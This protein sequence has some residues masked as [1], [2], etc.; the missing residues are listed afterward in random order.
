MR[1]SFKI[2]FSTFLIVLLSLSIG[3]TI[4]IIT[5]FH[6]AL[7]NEIRSAKEENH[8]TAIIMATSLSPYMYNY[9]SDFTAVI[10]GVVKNI[11]ANIYKS[12]KLLRVYDNETTL[13]YENI[14]K[15]GL[16]GYNKSK[17]IDYELGNKTAYM[18]IKEDEKYYIENVST[19]AMGDGKVYIETFSDIT[20]VLNF[21]EVQVDIFLKVFV[22]MG[23]ISGILNYIVTVWLTKPISQLSTATRSLSNGN[24]SMRVEI[25]TKDEVGELAKDFNMMA[26]SMEKTIGE[27]KE[28]AR[29][30]EEFVSNFAHELKTPLTAVIGYADMLRSRKMS[31][32]A[33]FLAANYIFTEGERLES[34]SLKMLELLVER[35]YTPEFKQINIKELI[36]ETLSLMKPAL[37]K[38]SIKLEE[39]IEDWNLYVDKDLMK[40]V[41]INLID[42]AQKAIEDIGVI[43]VIGRKEEKE[44]CIY[45]KD[46]GRGIPEKD[47]GKI[48]EAFYMVDKSRSRREG[49]AGLGLN[50]CMQII[51]IHKAKLKFESEIGK[52]TTVKII[53]REGIL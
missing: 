21:I 2:F 23:L 30:Q 51:K 38:K 25:K 7:R 10:E 24:L 8:M 9:S 45:I 13:V 17:L 46:N 50:I 33:T 48:T 26:D 44:Y 12:E 28:Y 6:I 37:I 53:M 52:G 18:I 34:L 3:G 11:E 40:T 49:G 32:E 1:F 35:N 19:I 31:E 41:I 27:L 43:K 16:E 36:E 14:G 22:V 15:V 5:N 20:G 29:R 42:N 47:L 4:L 39:T